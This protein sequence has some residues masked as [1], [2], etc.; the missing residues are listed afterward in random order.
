M[1][2]VNVLS[3][4]NGSETVDDANNASKCSPGLSNYFEYRGFLF[5]QNS[6]WSKSLPTYEFAQQNETQS[7]HSQLYKNNIEL[8]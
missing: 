7:E 4:P 3:D 1:R 6:G 5:I 2:D 8:L